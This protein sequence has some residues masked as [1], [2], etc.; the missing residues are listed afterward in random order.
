MTTAETERASLAFGERIRDAY[1][2]P[3]GPY[4]IIHDWRRYRNGTQQARKLFI[5][6]IIH[7]KRLALLVFCNLSAGQALSI[8]L[9][10]A[11]AFLKTEVRVCG[12]YQEAISIAETYLETGSLPPE[13]RRPLRIP[14]LSVKGYNEE[15]LAYLESIDWKTG[16]R[17]KNFQID[18]RHPLLPVF[19]TITVI[20]SS[21]EQTFK[22]R[23]EAERALREYQQSLERQVRERT[24]ELESSELRYRQLLDLTPTAIAV[25]SPELELIY[26]NTT[27]SALFGYSAAHFTEDQSFVSLLC[28]TETQAEFK[29]FLSSG[30]GVEKDFELR[31]LHAEHLFVQ[32]SVNTIPEALVVS[33]ADI[34]VRKKTE[35]KLFNLSQ[36]DELTGLFNRR[37]FVQVLDR[38]LAGHRRDDLPLSLIIL[39][40]DHF[41][42]VNDTWGH[43]AGDGVLKE[44]AQRI[45]DQVRGQ[46][47]FFRIGGEEFAVIMPDTN[48]EQGKNVAERLR[49]TIE[50]QAFRWGDASFS[51]TIS[52]GLTTA[53]AAAADSDSFFNTADARLYEAKEAGRNRVCC[54]MT[55]IRS[56]A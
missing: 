29:Q 21:L 36:R 11:L 14:R 25:L 49:T 48:I 2:S 42:D 13:K 27:F 50:Q 7:D 22:E 46:D 15:F 40:I 8:R 43:L 47:L 30:Y 23:D 19:D 32:A 28:K 1:L 20:R 55:I 33:F 37:H 5:D 26:V 6:S 51:L 3:Q 24:I 17:I 52:L 12:P 18:Y 56:E 10:R 45:A 53:M 44:L 54:G 35:S 38:E 9:A 4:V 41:K 31:T 16:R 34:T 39:D